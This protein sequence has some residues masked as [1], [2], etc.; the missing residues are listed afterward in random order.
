MSWARHVKD[1][2]QSSHFAAF[3]DTGLDKLSVLEHFMF[4]HVCIV[5]VLFY[6]MLKLQ[7]SVPGFCHYS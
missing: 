5:H 3:T 6:L 7:V 4:L 1:G 2:A